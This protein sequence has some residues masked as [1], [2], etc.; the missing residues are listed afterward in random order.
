MVIKTLVGN[1][2]RDISLKMLLKPL[3]NV[4]RNKMENEFLELTEISKTDLILS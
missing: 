3:Y 4:C 1:V 2:V